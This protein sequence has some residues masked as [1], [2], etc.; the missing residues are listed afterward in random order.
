MGREYKGR[1]YEKINKRRAKVWQLRKDGK[2]FREIAEI[3][4]VSESRAW[5]IML[6]AERLERQGRLEQYLV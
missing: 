5:Q 4:G 6:N 3:L 2:K 1:D